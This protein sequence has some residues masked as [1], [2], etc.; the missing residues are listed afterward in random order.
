[1][2]YTTKTIDIFTLPEEYSLAHCISADL[3][4]GKGI[5]VGFNKHFDM[6]HR[7]LSQFGTSL[8]T[9]WDKNPSGHCIHEDRVFNLVTKRNYWHKPTYKTLEDA[10]IECRN[11]CEF[12]N[13]EKL[14]MPQIGC[15]L[16]KLEWSKVSLMIQEIF[17]DTNIDIV[18]CKLA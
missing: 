16:D 5:A 10:L 17:K 12:L 8:I 9:S 6:R 4:M 18:I 15:G 1:M 3:A 2:N 14:A 13:I 7:L 11:Q